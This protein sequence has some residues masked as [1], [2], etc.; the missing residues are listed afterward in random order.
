MHQP[1]TAGDLCTR[2][3]V[4]ANRSL[5][6]NDAAQLMRSQHVGCLVV[7]DEAAAGRVPVGIL[8]D[9]DIVIAAVAKGLDP[10][11]LNVEDVMSSE[12]TTALESDT[13]L[14]VLGVM[15]RAGVRRVPVTDAQG[16][17]QGVLALDDIFEV[18]SEEM[19]LLA[20]A[21]TR[22]RKLEPQRRP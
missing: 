11:T 16:T 2:T 15:R 21:L 17:L 1:L 5:P 12:P 20:Q 19:G 8:T 4:I 18:V 22:E 7:V 9:R 10:R 3:T 14:D 13:L 6:L